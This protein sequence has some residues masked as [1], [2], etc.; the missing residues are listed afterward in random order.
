[1]PDRKRKL[2]RYITPEALMRLRFGEARRPRWDIGILCFRGQLGSEALARALGARPVLEKTLYGYSESAVHGDVH[3][4]VLGEARVVLVPR[5]LWGGPQTA[6]LVEE[7]VCLGARIILGF[8]VAGSLAADLPK[9]TQVVASA[10][11]VT[12]GT[13]RA[14]TTRDEVPA[15]AGLAAALG[16]AAVARGI[17]LVPVKVATVD[18]L[19]RETPADVHGWLRRGARAVNMETAPLYAAAAVCE[20]RSLWLGHISDTLS[21]DSQEWE[22]WRRPA[23]M[24]DITVSLMAGLLERIRGAGP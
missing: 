24:T 11:V 6:I 19:Y 1:M 15:D 21:L 17:D 9:G 20:V 8:G 3:E 10:G 18:A 13:S 22:S 2:A 16:A 7:L 12:D 5:C 14:Y 4:A 23:A